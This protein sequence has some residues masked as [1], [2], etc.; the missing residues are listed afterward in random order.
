MHADSRGITPYLSVCDN[1]TVVFSSIRLKDA[2]KSPDKL[3]LNDFH[4]ASISLE[5]KLS[6]ATKLTRSSAPTGAAR[7][8]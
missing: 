7:G 6:C 4:L 2:H 5:V 8:G 1:A 3:C